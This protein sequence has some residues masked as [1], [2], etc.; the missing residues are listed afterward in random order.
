M[1]TFMAVLLA[2]AGLVSL[3]CGTAV[4]AQGTGYICQYDC[5]Q[6]CGTYTCYTGTYIC[7]TKEKRFYLYQDPKLLGGCVQG[8]GSCLVVNYVCNNI[9]YPVSPCKGAC[10]IV[11]TQ[12]G[13]CIC[14]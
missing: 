1:K 7:T 14:P 10:C 5:T 4:W 9:Y 2:V 12:V 6:L 8:S 11:T 13:A 3:A